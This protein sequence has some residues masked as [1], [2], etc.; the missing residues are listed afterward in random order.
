MLLDYMVKARTKARTK[1]VVR[2]CSLFIVCLHVGAR[3]KYENGRRDVTAADLPDRSRG[4]R[5]D[6]SGEDAQLREPRLADI[7][8]YIYIYIYIYIE[9]DIYIYIHKYICIYVVISVYLYIYI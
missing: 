1:F 2:F 5:P 7:Y 8:V 4:R 3:A 6:G 9:R